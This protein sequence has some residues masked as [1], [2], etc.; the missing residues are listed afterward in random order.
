MKNITGIR[1]MGRNGPRTEKPDLRCLVCGDV[2]L[3]KPRLKDSPRKYC[4]QSCS[5]K[6]QRDAGFADMK[7]RM[8]V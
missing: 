3:G 1:G 5:A 7:E 4:N 2:I 8:G 6:A